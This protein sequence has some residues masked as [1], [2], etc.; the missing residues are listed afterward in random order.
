MR[1]LFIYPNN[2]S[3]VGF[4]Y[5]IASLSAV[6]KEQGNDVEL[7]Q[8]CDDI[9]PLPGRD[10]FISTIKGMK[11]DL[12]GFSVVTNQW[13]L[14]RQYAEYS[15]EATGVPI[16]CGGIHASIASKEVLQSGLFDFIFAG[17]TEETFPR[18]VRAYERTEDYYTIPGL[19]YIRDGEIRVNPLAPLPELKSLPMKDYGIFNFQEIIDAKDGWV[20]LMASRGCPF[21]CSYC[22]NHQMVRR[23]QKDL[24][25]SRAR[26]NY[27]RHHTV[28]Q[29]LEEIKY[30][31]ARYRNIKMFIFDDDLFTFKRDFVI[32]FSKAYQKVSDVP[33][34][35][36]A[37]VGLWDERRA[38]ALKEA[39][40]RIVK[41]GVESGSEKIR[42]KIMH[43][44]M[45]NR[46][47]R[48][49]IELVNSHGMH[50]S[51]FLMIGL[52]HENEGDVMDTIRLMGESLPG[53]FR[54]TFFY[55]FP[56]T[57]SYD[58]A[59]DGGFIN[60][61]KFH[62]MVNF[63][64]ASCLDLGAEM[65]LLLKKIG[66]L[67]PW[68]VNASSGLEVAPFYQ[69]QV[70]LIR[71]MGGEEWEEWSRDALK[72]EREYSDRFVGEGKSH[73]AVRYN[74]F[75]GIISDYFTKN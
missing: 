37:H 64:D 34:V 33:F 16:I 58:I 46:K 3:Q 7:I 51:C 61:E 30:L 45:S 17:E 20:G 39:G 72:V 42:T 74:R 49:S 53:R 50:S 25:C 23:Y 54:W 71:A 43:R 22:F 60:Y 55:P 35:V 1:V 57:E 73:Y 24:N 40:C 10:E 62:N 12:I 14:A 41:F 63:T 47:I 9:R 67:M 13:A 32:E 48:E 66:K 59:A 28:E 29:I 5:G 15:R 65:N 8:L 6:L 75:M 27:I 31:Q 36:N 11:P 69:E 70:Q 44:R 4:N 2:G 56:G 52:P 38:L 19:G 18:F 68:F 21:N 26:L